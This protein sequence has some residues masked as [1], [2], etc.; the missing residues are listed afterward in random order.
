MKVLKNYLFSSFYQVLIL[1][2]PVL[3][4]PY[5]SRVLGVEGIGINAFT[6]SI[7]GYFSLIATLGTNL[8]GN[9]EIA[10]Y[11]DKKFERSQA[12]WEIS[13]LSFI[14]SIITLCIF[15]VF[16]LFVNKYQIFYLLQGITILTAMFDISW[17]FMG[18]EKFK[19]TVLRNTVVKIITVI[20]I[21][22][23][24]HSESDLWLYIF[25]ISFGG[26]LSSL[27]LWPYLKEEIYKPNFKNLHIIQHLKPSLLLFLPTISTNIYLLGQKNLIGI[28]DSIK[29]AG[30]FSQSDSLM[31]MAIALVTSLGTVMLPRIANMFVNSGID[32]IKKVIVR[33]FSIVIGIGMGITFGIMG[34]SLKF[35]PFF[36]GTEFSMI[37]KVMMIESPIILL[38]AATSI[39]GTHYYLPLNKTKRFTLSTIIAALFNVILNIIIIP[40]FGLYGGTFVAVL[41]ELI[42]ATYQYYYLYKDL[43]INLINYDVLKYFVAGISMFILVFIANH[44]LDMTFLNLF[45]Q[46]LIGMF[47]YVLLNWRLNT[48]LWKISRNMI[49]KLKN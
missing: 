11:Q 13:F 7:V 25:I 18:R 33:D 38:F 19:L 34:I 27:S 29:H 41:S 39:F 37:G 10:Y 26:L 9:R 16:V 44:I 21:F 17:Y 43:N 42:L 28:L 47:T 4:T 12:F 2:L 6:L 20:S 49:I 22:L 31:R 32:E 8:Y 5:I 30:F 1:L 36:F 24:I 14:S 46:I 48:G 35:A 40:Y 23:F 3:T 45:I 15:F